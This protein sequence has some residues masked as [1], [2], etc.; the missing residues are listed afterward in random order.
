[1]PLKELSLVKL[2]LLV[3]QVSLKS[4]PILKFGSIKTQPLNFLKESEFLV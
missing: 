2:A 1:M 3:L 4:T